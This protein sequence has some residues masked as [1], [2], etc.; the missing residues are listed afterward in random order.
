MTMIQDL[1]NMT[2]KFIPVDDLHDGHLTAMGTVVGEP[3][4][5]PSRKTVLVTVRTHSGTMFTD[6][7]SARAKIAVWVPET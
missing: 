5:S 4:F 6:R 3:K 1:D 7:R 2:C